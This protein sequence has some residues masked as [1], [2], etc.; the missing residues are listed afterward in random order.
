VTLPAALRFTEHELVGYRRVWRG[1]AVSTFLTPI[2]Y[3]LAM[4]VGLGTLVD[5]G[6]GDAALE[7][8]YLAFL[9]P[10][11]LAATAMQTGVGDASWPV[12]AGIEWRKTYHAVLATPMEV[13]DLVLGRLG[14]IAIRLTLMATWYAVVLTLFGIAPLT[15]TLLAVPLAILLGLSFS[16]PM[17][18]F[19]ASVK[20]SQALT[21]VFRFG[22]IP[23]FLF[24]GTFFPIEQLPS[25]VR[26]LSR[27]IPLW[28]G[29]QLIRPTVLGTDSA[30]SPWAHTAVLVAFLAIGTWVAIERMR[31]RLKP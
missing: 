31:R 26:P 14:W 8:S 1:T 13:H 5:R 3:L 12:M 24:S 23:L 15:R 27:I 11:L 22:V 6:A 16:G 2:L 21:S 4:G 17:L 9:G 28:H 30:W 18:A 19:T 7:V 25:A 10:G 20:N 29:V